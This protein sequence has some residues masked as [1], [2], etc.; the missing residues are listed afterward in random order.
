MWSMFSRRVARPA[1]LSR[2]LLV[3]PLDDRIVP[4]FAAPLTLGVGHGPA[5]VAVGDF[6]RD[7]ARDLVVVNRDSNTV[8]VLL[9][10]GHRSFPA[11]VNYALGTVP[12]A[13]AARGL[14]PPRRPH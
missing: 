8:S 1:R 6:N 4:S 10:D 12:H 5:A 3:E 9:G 11:P 2:P 14:Y 7:G 13:P